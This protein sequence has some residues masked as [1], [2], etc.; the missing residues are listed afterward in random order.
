MTVDDIRRL[1]GEKTLGMSEF[2]R[3]GRFDRDCV[4]VLLA[5]IDRLS[6]LNLTEE[7]RLRVEF[8][9]ANGWDAPAMSGKGVADDS[10]QRGGTDEVIHP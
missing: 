9:R 4:G 10:D 6:L 7:E 2:P 3:W 8:Y 1:H 5:E